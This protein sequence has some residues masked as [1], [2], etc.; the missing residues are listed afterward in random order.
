MVQKEAGNIIKPYG[1]TDVLFYY[2]KISKH[3]KNF[4]EGK[5]IAAKIWLPYGKIP[6]FLRRGSNM[7]PLHIQE[8]DAVDEKMLRLRSEM[9]L[10]KA[11]G[12][13]SRQQEKIWSYFVPRKLIDFFYA[14]NG[15][16]PGNPID[17]LFMDLDRGEGATE[18]QA[19]AAAVGLIK[20]IKSDKKLAKLARFRIFI[21]WTGSSFHI[22]LLFEKK[23][24][25]AFYNTYF[26]YSKEEPE[27]SFI[28]RW[29]RQLNEN[30]NFK[31][32]KIKV[33]G[34]HEKIPRAIIIDPS[35]T[36]SG[37]LARAPFSLHMRSASEIDGIAI[38][39]SE[40]QL[41]DKNLIKNM[42]SYTPEKV[43]NNLKELAK[44][45][46]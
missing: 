28:G 13:I 35:Q 23:Y 2:S 24:Q 8:L 31:K 26:K 7:P 20:I 5:E 30:P 32:L 45:L 27:A 15:E 14:T 10:D 29:A 25:N 43:L 22:Y 42:K 18:E 3:L 39:L 19:R 36:P 41:N 11:K 46:P 16:H 12:K 4:L 40:K 44:N 38:P 37:K 21:M 6:F 1:H 9:D 33:S 17:R 34:G